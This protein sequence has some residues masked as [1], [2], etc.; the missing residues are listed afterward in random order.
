MCTPSFVHLSFSIFTSVVVYS[1][2]PP[3]NKNKNR[4][5]DYSAALGFLFLSFH[6]YFVNEH[7]KSEAKKNAEHTRMYTIFSCILSQYSRRLLSIL[8]RPQRIIPQKTQE[9]CCNALLLWDYSFF[10]EDCT[11]VRSKKKMHST[12]ACTPSFT[13]FFLNIHVSC[14]LFS[15]IIIYSRTTQHYRFKHFV[16]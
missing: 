4:T 11:K 2:T 1:R 9:I 16:F 8:A 12:H 10:K 14:C 5:V 7:S 6:L 15:H 13:P 3:K